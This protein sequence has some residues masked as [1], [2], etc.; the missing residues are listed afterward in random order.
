MRNCERVESDRQPPLL[1]PSHLSAEGKK[2]QRSCWK[3][4]IV[5]GPIREQSIFAGIISTRISRGLE[6]SSVRI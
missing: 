4:R 6:V 2:F 1:L 5:K 3:N